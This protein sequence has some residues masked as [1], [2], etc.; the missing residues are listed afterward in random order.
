MTGN[1]ENT[2]SPII[3]LGPTM[4][5][6]QAAS[7]TEANFK[8]PAAMG[9][10]TRAVSAGASAIVLIDGV[11][12]TGPSVWHKEIL[13]ALGEGIPVIG[14]SSMGALRAAEL[15]IFG[16]LGFGEVFAQ[17]A[18]GRLTDDDEV[19]VVHGPAETGWI[20]MSDAMVDI[21]ASLNHAV[22]TGILGLHEAQLVI[23][24][25]KNTHFKQRNLEQSLQTV[26]AEMKS[27]DDRSVFSEWFRTHAVNLK[28]K[29]CKSLLEQLPAVLEDAKGALKL[30]RPVVPTL[31]F[32]RLRPFGY[33]NQ[34]GTPS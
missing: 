13:L 18:S 28:R 20:Q 1:T 12:E 32:E 34:K 16:M 21:R 11:F 17:Y 33:C 26:F 5:H 24:H 30:A 25:A 31:Y 9:D 19:A 3:F 6:W 10:I 29:D 15:H 2:P 27:P 8:P 7:L 23:E 4:D 22:K 14:A